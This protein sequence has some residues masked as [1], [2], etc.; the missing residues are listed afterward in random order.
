MLLV[1][2]RLLPGV[3]FR[4]RG[5]SVNQSPNHQLI[6]IDTLIRKVLM[7]DSSI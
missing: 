7:M 4:K 6:K 1:T 2:Y 5:C 3:D